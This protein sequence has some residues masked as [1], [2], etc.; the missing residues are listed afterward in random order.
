MAWKSSEARFAED[1]LVA[2]TVRET[3]AALDSVITMEDRGGFLH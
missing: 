1:V 2:E 3:E